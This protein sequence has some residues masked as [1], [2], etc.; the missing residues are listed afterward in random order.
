MQVQYNNTS[1]S[2]ENGVPITPSDVTLLTK[3]R[4]LY[5]GVSGDLNIEHVSGTSVL[6]LNVPVGWLPF[7]GVRVMSTGTT[8][9]SIVALY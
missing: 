7:S 2:I 9:T 6:Y 8:A 5:I 1:G 4:G 3:F